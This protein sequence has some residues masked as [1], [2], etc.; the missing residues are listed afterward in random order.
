MQ[1][2]Y[3]VLRS[4]STSVRLPVRL[5]RAEPIRTR[6]FR[7]GAAAYRQVRRSVRILFPTLF[8]LS[9]ASVA[10]AQGTMDFSGAQT[11]MGTFKTFAMYAGAVT[12]ALTEL[13]RYT[14]ARI[15]GNHPAETTGRFIAAK[16]EHDTA[17]PV[18]GYAAPQLHTHAVIFNVTEREDGSKRA[19]DPKAFFESQTYATAVYQSHLMYR[20]REL[21]YELERG[22]SGA[23]EI[24]GYSQK[25]LDAS[26][27]R[28]EKIREH[29]ERVGRSGPEAAQIGYVSAPVF[30]VPAVA[31]KGELNILTAGDPIAL[32]KVQPLF[33]AL[34]QKTWPL[35]ADPKHANI[36]K[37]AGNLMIALAIEAMGEATALTES[38][39]LGAAD[40]LNIVTN[41]MFASPS[42]KRY[43]DN[44]ARNRYEPGFKLT[45]GLKDVNLALDAAK[46]KSA[47]L[48]AA[49]I[50]RE[51][52]LQAI[53]QGLGDK[54]WSALAQA[55][56]RRAGVR[57]AD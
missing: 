20:L 6:R 17:R 24:K 11:L 14:Q 23:P 30:G 54:D 42:Y 25:C 19:L 8:A 9:L 18:N 31:E 12:V 3:P 32:T 10:H 5:G 52:L 51:N 43:G 50:V 39:G 45:L 4:D 36:A 55:T 53:D 7:T 33:D 57:K 48:G 27:P 21:G 2:F 47:D 40:F 13:E 44:I 46:V 1:R 15:G 26:S 16:F 56:Q 49:Q 22:R 37:I 38:Y 34:G 35:G 29:L 41:I 28:S